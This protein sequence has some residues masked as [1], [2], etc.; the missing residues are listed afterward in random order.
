MPIIPGK[1]KADA[2]CGIHSMYSVGPNTDNNVCV[3][4]MIAHELFSANS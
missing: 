1:N 2:S 4:I 3:V